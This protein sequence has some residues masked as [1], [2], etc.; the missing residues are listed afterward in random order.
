[1]KKLELGFDLSILGH[2]VGGIARYSA[3][4]AKALRELEAGREELLDLTTVDVSGS[5]PGREPLDEADI[6]LGLPGYLRVPL[7]RRLPIRLGWERKGRTGRLSRAVRCDVYHHSGVQPCFPR[8]SVSVIAIHDLTAVTNPEWHTAQTLGFFEVEADLVRSG[9]F[10]LTGSSWAEGEIGRFFGLDP[11]GGRVRAVGGAAPDSFTPGT[12][13]EGFLAQNHLEA[14]RFLL[15]VGN[16]EPRKNIPFVLRVHSKAVRAGSQ[17][18]LVIAGSAGWGMG[19]HMSRS[20]A[21]RRHVRVLRSVDDNGLLSLYRGCAAVLV[22]SLTEGLGLVALEA[23]ACGAP[24]IASDRG[25]HP[26]TVGNGGLL[27]DAED[28]DSWLDV[29]M[30]LG[31]DHP[32]ER[33]LRERSLAREVDSWSDVAGRALEFYREAAG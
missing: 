31:S 20:G 27:L 24:L 15:M 3:C 22:P 7:A 12:P 33:E 23:N 13:D 26:E 21:G 1:M 2:A 17:L 19:E 9:S 8:G 11:G 29:M 6:V 4:L 28:E 10:V 5:H 30:R 25:A 16:L 14:N 18:P 32:F